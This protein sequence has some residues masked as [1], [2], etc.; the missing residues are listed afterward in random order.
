MRINLEAQLKR[1]YERGFAEGLKQGKLHK[2]ESKQY[3]LTLGEEEKAFE[4]LTEADRYIITHGWIML[5]DSARMFVE[6]FEPYKFRVELRL[7]GK[8]SY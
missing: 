5:D 7:I 4:S 8:G 6:Y 2:K 1:A 3:I